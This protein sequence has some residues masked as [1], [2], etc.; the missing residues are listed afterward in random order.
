MVSSV[1]ALG[2]E[3]KAL[4]NST[5]PYSSDL[6]QFLTGAWILRSHQGSNLY[7]FMTQENVQKQLIYPYS[8]KLDF[9]PYR[10]LPVVAA[11]FLPLTLI[12][13][14][15]SYFTDFVINLLLWVTAALFLVKCFKG[16]LFFRYWPLL[17]LGFLPLHQALQLSQ[18]T[19]VLL[20]VLVFSYF[21]MG[22]SHFF[23]AGMIFSL[24]LI[25]PQFF[26]AGLLLFTVLAL[27]KISF[28]TGAFLG[29]G[30]ILA[31]SVFI[32]GGRTVLAYPGFVLATETAN[33]GSSQ[34]ASL[35][36]PPVCLALIYPL[37]VIF[38]VR[39]RRQLSLIYA[40]LIATLALPVFSVHVLAS[41]MALLLL[42]VV[43]LFSSG[44]PELINLAA[45]MYLL[46]NLLFYTCPRILSWIIAI[47]V[48]RM[49]YCFRGLKIKYQNPMTGQI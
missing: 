15:G 23:E 37:F 11:G 32:A 40:F 1:L 12:P 47:L 42:P 41:D 45:V 21:L 22:K 8:L 13:L 9:L 29:A 4:L 5:R 34:G 28:L 7:S 43:I 31:L 18:L 3:F 35:G 25:K 46:I 30:L 24:T 26:A 17:F 38:F 49:L 19:T 10:S 6:T 44:L 14:P 27:R 36:L 48:F 39:V 20:L 16:I 33:L 2:F